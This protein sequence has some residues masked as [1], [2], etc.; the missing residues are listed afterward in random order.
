MNIDSAESIADELAVMSRRKTVS[1]VDLK[2]A[3]EKALRAHAEEAVK[4]A[5]KAEREKREKL[6]DEWLGHSS[7]DYYNKETPS[8]VVN[9]GRDGNGGVGT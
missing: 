8:G 9:K 4:D 3:I 7:V 6:A 2:N 5:L 1:C